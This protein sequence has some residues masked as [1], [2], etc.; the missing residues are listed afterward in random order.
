[1]LRPHPNADEVFSLQGGSR[2]N[3]TSFKKMGVY[4]SRVFEGAAFSGGWYLGAD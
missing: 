3:A 1:M 4:P 2:K